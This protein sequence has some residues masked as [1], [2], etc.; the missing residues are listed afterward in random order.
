MSDRNP[1]KKE[2]CGLVSPPAGKITMAIMLLFFSTS[3]LFAT[4]F[5]IDPVN[6]SNDGD[7]SISNPWH[8]LQEVV[9]Q[10]LIES[11]EY[12]TPYDPDNP[13]LI[14]KNEGAPVKA[15][16]TLILRNG[17]HGELF[18]RNYINTDYI[19]IR[20]ETGHTPWL[21]YVRLQACHKWRLTGISVSPEP[22]GSYLT[23]KLVFIESHGWQGPSSLIEVS[24]CV[25][26]ST[27]SPWTEAGDWVNKAGDGIYVLA[28]SVNVLNNDLRNIRF[29]ITMKG[30]HIDA[31]GNSVV[32]FSGDGLRLLGSLLSGRKKYHQKLL[33]GGQ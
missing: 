12:V 15:G 33:C 30:N 6:G 8:T 26:Q 21:K 20:A 25:I 11:Y 17:L 4:S 1:Y 10:N 22:Y 7:G 18:L 32:N 5:Y 19:T 27:A 2:K 29:G 9:E 31:V 28:D 3:G 23:D 14:I 16:D 24:Y 13:Q